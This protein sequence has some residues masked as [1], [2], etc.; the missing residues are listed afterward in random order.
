MS[1]EE[2]NSVEPQNPLRSLKKTLQPRPRSDSSHWPARPAEVALGYLCMSFNRVNVNVDMYVRVYRKVGRYQPTLVGGTTRLPVPF[3]GDGELGEHRIR[4]STTCRCIVF[5][6]QPRRFRVFLGGFATHKTFS[7]RSPRSHAMV[8]FFRQGRDAGE[9]PWSLYLSFFL[10]GVG[11]VHATLRP[12]ARPALTISLSLS[13]SLSP[14][15]EGWSKP[16][17]IL[18]TRCF[19]G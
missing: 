8:P 7:H 19:I 11:V 10:Q 17:G 3:Q 6:S 14:G 4:T 2:R 1:A 13:L 5:P 9:L 16:P 15:H 12:S 18:P